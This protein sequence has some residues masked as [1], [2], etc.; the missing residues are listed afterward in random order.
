MKRLL[1]ELDTL[2]FV[3]GYGLIVGGV[4]LLSTAGAL[5]LAGLLLCVGSVLLGRRS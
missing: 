1:Q 3:L 4:A 2:G 5:V